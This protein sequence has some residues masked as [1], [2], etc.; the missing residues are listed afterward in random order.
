MIYD[1]L[2]GKLT[3]KILFIIKVITID[4]IELFTVNLGI[5]LYFVTLIETKERLLPEHLPWPKCLY[6]TGPCSNIW[7]GFWKIIFFFFYCI[8]LST[9]RSWEEFQT[10]SCWYLNSCLLQDTG[11]KNILY[12]FCSCTTWKKSRTSVICLRLKAYF[13]P[14]T[15]LVGK[16]HLGHR[17]EF[18]PTR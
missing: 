5:F 8:V 15:K 2:V 9:R 13:V 11:Q 18:L 4:K 7:D 6:S 1:S 16:W 17:P 10:M 3:T 14:R 12:L